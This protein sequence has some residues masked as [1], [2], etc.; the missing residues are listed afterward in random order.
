MERAKCTLH[1]SDE[2]KQVR[3]TFVP[4]AAASSLLVSCLPEQLDPDS[5]IL[6][7]LGLPSSDLCNRAPYHATSIDHT[8][9]MC[10][11]SHWY[12]LDPHGMLL[13]C[14]RNH[15]SDTLLSLIGPA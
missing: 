2:T 1:S 9:Y 3:T 11:C 12:S 15:F 4:S 6:L 5:G 7:S 8:G 13:Q 14:S 10:L